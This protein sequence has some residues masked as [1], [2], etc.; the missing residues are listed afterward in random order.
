MSPLQNLLGL[1]AGAAILPAL[2]MLI[3]SILRARLARK[4]PATPLKGAPHA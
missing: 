2:G 3:G 1:I 4:P